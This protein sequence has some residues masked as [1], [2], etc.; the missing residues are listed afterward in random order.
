MVGWPREM[1]SV[2][3]SSGFWAGRRVFVTGHTGFKGSWLTLMLER[4]NARTTGFALAPPSDPS[5][6]EIAQAGSGMRDLRGDVADLDALS[7]A[8]HEA[9]PEIVIHMAAQP[10]VQWGYA[11]PVL[12]YRTNVMG[13]VNLLQAAR[14]IKSVR[15]IVN[16]TTDKCYDNREWLWAYRENDPLGGHDPYSSSKACAEFVTN[17]FRDSFFQDDARRLVSARA[18]NVIGG[19]DFAADRIL[20][21]A[22]RAFHA[23]RALKVRNPKAVR[24]WQHVLEPLCGYLML[25][26]QIANDAHAGINAWNFGPGARSERSVGDLLDVFCAAWG[27]DAHVIADNAVHPAEARLLRL[28]TSQAQALLGWSPLLD[29]EQSVAWTV[30]WYRAFAAR[31]DMRALTIRQVESYLGQAVRLTAPAPASLPA[32]QEDIAHADRRA[33]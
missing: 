8:M 7:A 1:E 22:F 24:P 29:F 19:G 2:V 16:V 10:L 15:A 4:L 30:D 11:D 26:E 25:A 12:T 23:G 6:F 32:L 5:L 31:E 27:R 13:T 17:A 28:D 3:I 21:D 14:S 18:G 20:P 33:L 9:E